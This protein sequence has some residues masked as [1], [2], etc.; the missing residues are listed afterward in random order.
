[1][2]TDYGRVLTASQAKPILDYFGISA[3]SD[4]GYG[5]MPVN[6]GGVDYW[7]AQNE[8]QFPNPTAQSPDGWHIVYAPSQE[9]IDISKPPPT[10]EFDWSSLLT[11]GF[12]AVGAYILI[13]AL[14][15]FKD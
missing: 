4:L 3:D 10:G 13:N 6:F 9:E 15:I 1:M 14:K 11:L 2:S 7:I 8:V 12:V 5:G